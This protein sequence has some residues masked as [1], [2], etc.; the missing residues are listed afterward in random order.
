[1]TATNARTLTGAVPNSCYTLTDRGTYDYLNSKPAGTAGLQ[2]LSIIARDNS[3]S[4]P[5]ARTP[6][7]TTSTPTS[8]IRTSPARP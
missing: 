6:S 1:M 2:N 7:S 3:A 5:A 4:A 8:S